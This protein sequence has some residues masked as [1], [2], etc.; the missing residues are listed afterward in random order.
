MRDWNPYT[1]L[2]E[3]ENA[4]AALENS[5]TLSQTIKYRVSISPSH[6]TPNGK[7]NMSTQ[8]LVH[9]IHSSIIHNY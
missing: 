1:L 6:A 5:L 2:V 8:K 7:E 4:T 3:I 9:N